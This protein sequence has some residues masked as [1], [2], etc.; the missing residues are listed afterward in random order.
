MSHD[1]ILDKPVLALFPEDLDG[2]RILDVACGFGFWA[3]Y[4]RIRKQGEPQIIGLDIWKPYLIR[5][6]NVGIYD[7]LVLADAKKLPFRKT[8]D[9][10]IGCELLEHLREKEGLNTLK[11]LERTGTGRIIVS[12]PTDFFEQAEAHGNP[13]QKHHSFWSRKELANLGYRTEIIYDPPLPRTLKVADKIRRLIFRLPR[14]GRGEL[15]AH[16]SL[17]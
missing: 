12:T 11:E 7:G 15:I 1:H 16:K 5:L 14:P 6:K 13:Y 9:V 17:A 2:Y 8:F 4:L 3:F 10:I